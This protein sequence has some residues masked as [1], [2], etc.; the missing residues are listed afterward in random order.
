[1]GRRDLDRSC[2]YEWS[3]VYVY[4]SYELIRTDKK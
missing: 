1:V 2:L 4:S 3:A